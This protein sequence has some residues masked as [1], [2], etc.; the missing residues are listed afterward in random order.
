M[1]RGIS[2]SGLDEFLHLII[3]GHP[4]FILCHIVAYVLIGCDIILFPSH[5]PWMQRDLQSH[6]I[7]QKRYQSLFHRDW[8]SYSKSNEQ[9]AL[10]NSASSLRGLMYL[11]KAS[12]ANFAGH[13]SHPFGG[14]SPTSLYSIYVEAMK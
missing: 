7:H 2:V 9:L 6:C 1:P 12:C 10:I 8:I 5:M 11:S 13:N 4:T 3:S 14:V